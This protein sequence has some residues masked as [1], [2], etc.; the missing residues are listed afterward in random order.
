MHVHNTGRREIHAGL[1]FVL[2]M[3]AF[4]KIAYRL[5]SEIMLARLKNHFVNDTFALSPVNRAPKHSIRWPAFVEAHLARGKLCRYVLNLFNPIQRQTN[6]PFNN[7]CITM[8][9]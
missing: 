3:R 6:T 9:N 5:S 2:P 7:N 4:D 1:V 8:A